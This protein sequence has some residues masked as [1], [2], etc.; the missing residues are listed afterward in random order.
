[1]NK[2]AT[3]LDYSRRI[4]RV[5]RH[6]GAHLD[7]PLELGALAEVA[8]F[9]PCHFHRIYRALSGETVAETIRR[10]RLHRAAGERPQRTTS[11]LMPTASRPSCRGRSRFQLAPHVTQFLRPRS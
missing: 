8:C 1:M 4:E 10:H 2:P 6:I 5:A 7:Q 11:T 9:S 3:V